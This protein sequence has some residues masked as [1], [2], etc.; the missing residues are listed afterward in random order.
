[1]SALIGG[2]SHEHNESVTDP[3]P[4][5]AWTDF[6]AGTGEI[7]DKCRTFAES[8][9]YGAPLG[10]AANGAKYNQVIDGRLY[11]YQQEWSNKGHECRQRL[12]FTAS[13]APTAT[14]TSAAVKGTEM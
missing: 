2:L 10:T 5:N 3:E 14:F 8:T 13:E 6:G 4:N 9:E 7:G 1:D 12:A 11:W